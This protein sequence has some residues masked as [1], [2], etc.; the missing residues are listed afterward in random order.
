MSNEL[1]GIKE[2][3]AE[4]DAA[5]AD[6]AARADRGL[7][8]E[9]E[10]ALR[11]WLASDARR[12]GAYAR[13]RGL[14]LYTQRAAALGPQYDPGSFTVPETASMRPSRRRFLAAGSALAASVAVGGLLY[15][16]DRT[17]ST[18]KGEM[19]VVPLDD[20]SIVTLNTASRIEVQFRPEARHIRLLEGE[21]LFDVAHDAARPFVVFAGDTNVRAIGTSFSVTRLKNAPVQVLVR[22]GVVE[23]AREDAPVTAPVRVTAHN[24]AVAASGKPQ[25]AAAPVQAAE[26]QRELAWREGRIGFEGETLRDAA[27]KFA[28]Y[29]DTEIVI[30]DAAMAR[31]EIAG[32]FQANDPVGFAKAIAV[33]LGGRAEVT[34][35]KVRLTR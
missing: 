1:D 19:R 11:A 26:L 21:A 17:I 3:A 5:A 8:A 27:A 25:I 24:R 28:R 6:W 13:V 22:E 14:A 29:S 18:R 10:T 30:D 35:G 33:S 34:G 31:E 12:T 32:L 7:S 4:I 23:V 16:Q 20:G 15:M 2:T 9:E